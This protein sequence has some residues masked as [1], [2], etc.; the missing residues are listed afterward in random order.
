[1]TK[2][3]VD[4]R[5]SGVPHALSRTYPSFAKIVFATVVAYSAQIFRGRR[6]ETGSG[7]LGIHGCPTDCGRSGAS[8][9]DDL[10]LR[11]PSDR[12]VL[13]ILVSLVQLP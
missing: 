4:P 8:V 1:M 12:R 5:L 2:S 9:F 7:C 6:A 3:N 13:I 10:C 11:W